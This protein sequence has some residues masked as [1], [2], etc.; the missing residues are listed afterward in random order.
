M[1]FFCIGKAKNSLEEPSILLF[2]ILQTIGTDS[3][4]AACPVQD[5]V[6]TLSEVKSTM[7]CLGKKLSG[8]SCSFLYPVFH[9][10][11]LFILQKTF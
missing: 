11:V 10:L 4:M 3:K 1:S 8:I 5:G 6:L 7:R 2:K 9:L